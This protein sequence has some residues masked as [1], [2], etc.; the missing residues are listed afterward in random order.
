[1]DYNDLTVEESM[2]GNNPITIES[3][4]TVSEALSEMKKSKVH[5]L[6][7]IDNNKIRG[8]ISHKD[9]LYSSIR[10]TS[11]TKITSFIKHTPTISPEKDIIDAATLLVSSNTR[12]L[13]VTKNNEIV[14]LI[15][16]YDLV[17]TVSEIKNTS[18]ASELMV[19]PVFTV[20][21]ADS[22][23]KAVSIMKKE[24]IH[25]IPVLNEETESIEGMLSAFDIIKNKEFKTEKMTIG[26]IKG[27]HENYSSLPVKSFISELVSYCSPQDTIQDIAKQFI[28]NNVSSSIVLENKNII[29]IITT[30]DILR[31]LIRKSTT[32]DIKVKIS[33]I[34]H[35]DPFI[36]NKAISTAE[37]R[38]EKL[39]N[40][41]EIID[42]S[43]HVKRQHDNH[44][45]RIYIVKTHLD[46][47]QGFYKTTSED[48]DLNIAL[49]NALSKLED[50]A[51]KDKTKN[52][53]QIRRKNK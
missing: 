44:N 18:I 7:V 5:Q 42:F 25:H 17:K 2:Q 39:K 46:T 50:L 8:T 21:E 20:N 47:K 31:Y 3:D 26:E 12:G 41:A 53:E 27:E 35:E 30:K 11:T 1:M 40:I 23:K 16:E 15:S 4:K 48:R 33:G 13:P 36:I 6:I 28:N 52:L 34:K 38:E 37:N 45:D 19:S 43:I 14:S 22:L 10:D 24:S 29:G 51:K 9:L 32:K 49:C